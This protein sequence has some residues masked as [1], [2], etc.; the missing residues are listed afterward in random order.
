MEETFRDIKIVLIGEERVGKTNIISRMM[1]NQ[2]EYSYKSTINPTINEKRMVLKNYSYSFRV[3]IWD[4]SGQERFRSLNKIFYREASIALIVFNITDRKTYEGINYWIQEMKNSEVSLVCLVA[5]YCEL[6]EA[7][8][9]SI[10]E[11]KRI[12]DEN[13][14]QIYMISAKNNIGIQEMLKDIITKYA[15]YDSYY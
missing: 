6:D 9:V 13:H 8:A 14:L 12:G 7:Y 11:L 1:D 2:F 5:N 4:T 10:K 15:D 3:N